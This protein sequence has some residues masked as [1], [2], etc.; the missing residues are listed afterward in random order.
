MKILIFSVLGNLQIEESLEEL[1]PACTLELLSMPLTHDNSERRRGA[2]SALQELLRQGLEV[3]TSCRVQDWSCFLL[4]ALS[5]LMS[6]EIVDL[7][8]WVDLA[9]IRKN[10]K[11][12][13]S[14]NQR[15]VIDF[16]CFYMVMIAHIALGFSTGQRDLVSLLFFYIFTERL[17]LSLS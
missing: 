15:I 3:E 8:S 12:L 2:I 9:T 7:F 6:K 4:Q 14:Q 11:S 13:E 17:F 16:S 5:R 10:K 1:A